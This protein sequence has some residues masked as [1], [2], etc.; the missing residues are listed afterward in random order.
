MPHFTLT[1]ILALI[2]LAVTFV[3]RAINLIYAI[4]DLVDDGVK[5]NSAAKPEWLSRIQCV[6]T[7]LEYI[8][9]QLT[10]VADENSYED[11]SGDHA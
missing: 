2:R 10:T 8:G 5:N 3:N 1:A 11:A 4:V 9:S 6:L 7:E